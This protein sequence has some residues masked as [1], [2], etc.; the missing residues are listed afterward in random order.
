MTVLSTNNVSC[1]LAVRPSGC[2]AAVTNFLPP[3]DQRRFMVTKTGKRRYVF[4]LPNTAEDQSR[5]RTRMA[6]A[7]TLRLG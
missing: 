1:L 6:I 7:T 2:S 4:I 5:E 3:G